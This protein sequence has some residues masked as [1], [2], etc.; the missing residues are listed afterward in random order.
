VPLPALA[1]PQISANALRV[2]AIRGRL[3]AAKAA[4]GTW[5]SSRAWSRNTP[6]PVTSDSRPRPPPKHPLCRP[7]QPP[8]NHPPWSLHRPL[9][10]L[11]TKCLLKIAIDVRLQ[12]AS[13]RSTVQ[14]QPRVPA[15]SA[16]A[17]ARSLSTGGVCVGGEAG[18]AVAK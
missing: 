8:A 18:T 10:R 13:A 5:R 4:D 9:K 14:L 1:T 7:K 16:A 15:A 11:S 3:K 6:P 2:A 12:A 17:M